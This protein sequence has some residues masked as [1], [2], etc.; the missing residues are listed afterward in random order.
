[1]A[2][3]DFQPGRSVR[4]ANRNG[5]GNEADKPQQTLFSWAEFIAAGPV[6][7]RFCKN[8]PQ[9]A[10]ASLFEWALTAQGRAGRRGT[11]GLRYEGEVDC[12]RRSKQA[13]ALRST[14]EP[15]SA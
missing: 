1:M 7:P 3:I 6:G 11:L 2:A 15:D 8:K 13:T 12:K 10:T 9:P 14:D 5:R 4:H